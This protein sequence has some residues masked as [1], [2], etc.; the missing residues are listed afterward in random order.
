MNRWVRQRGGWPRIVRNAIVAYFEQA[1]P[2]MAAALSYYSIFAGG[3]VLVLTLLLGSALFGET[4]T[5]EAVGQV[6]Q[7]LLPAGGDVSALAEQV[8]QT[9]TPTVSL[10]LIAGISSMLGFTRALSTMLNVTLKTEGTEP[11]GRT[12]YVGPLLVLAVFGLLWGAW[13]LKLVIELL[14]VGWDAAASWALQLL[15]DGLAPLFLAMVYFAII[16]AVVPRVQLDR[17]EIIVPACIGATVWEAARHVFGWLMGGDS[18]Y[19]RV[20]GPLGGVVALL[21]WVYLSSITLT[22]TGQLAWA[23]AMERRGRGQLAYRYPRQAGLQGW[24]PRYDGDNA[25]NEDYDC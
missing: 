2:R 5:R 13:S 17:R 8:V 4:A 1:G 10:A 22:L 19:L 9:S 18:D 24:M 11:F 3:P 7:R 21:G 6:V 23:Y 12:F 14:Q 25:V 20:F 16:L 15:A